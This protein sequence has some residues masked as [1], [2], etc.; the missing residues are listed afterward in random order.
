MHKKKEMKDHH[1]KDHMMEEHHKKEHMMKHHHE[2]KSNAG[3]TALKAK[4]AKK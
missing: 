2:K 3:K 4:I 1:K